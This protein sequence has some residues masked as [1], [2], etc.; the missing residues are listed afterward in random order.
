ME[1]L[2]KYSAFIITAPK[3]SLNADLNILSRVI[4]S[5]NIYF[6]KMNQFVISFLNFRKNSLLFSEIRC[7][8]KLSNDSKLK[9]ILSTM[10]RISKIS[11]LL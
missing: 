3:I 5:A 7:F 10:A 2:Y 8:R 4:L 1:I 9:N 11:A 6:R